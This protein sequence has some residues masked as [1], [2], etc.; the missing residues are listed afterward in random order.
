TSRLL[1][2]EACRRTPRAIPRAEMQPPA[3]KPTA[4]SGQIQRATK[5]P[6][7]KGQAPILGSTCVLPT[8]WSGPPAGEGP[9][10]LAGTGPELRQDGVY[11]ANGGQGLHPPANASRDIAISFLRLTKLERDI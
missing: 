4:R 2:L 6:K 11:S 1:A 5:A 10:T 9:R 8:C 3:M 7:V